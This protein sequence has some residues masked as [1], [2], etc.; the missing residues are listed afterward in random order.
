M[1][2][3]L[4]FCRAIQHH[5]D[6]VPNR[7]RPPWGKM[8]TVRCENCGLVRE[9]IIDG[10]GRPSHTNY[11]KPPSHKLAPTMSR[12]EWRLQLLGRARRKKAS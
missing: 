8:L 1:A 4:T 12:G 6:I 5:W 11:I 7:R 2:V 9:Q 10:N 3:D